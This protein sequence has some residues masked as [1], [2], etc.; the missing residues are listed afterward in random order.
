VY[1]AMHETM[2]QVFCSI[3]TRDSERTT[4]FASAMAVQNWDI[5]EVSSA[6]SD[7]QYQYY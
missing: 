6:T 5:Y 3:R 4:P 1:D 2:Q 7:G